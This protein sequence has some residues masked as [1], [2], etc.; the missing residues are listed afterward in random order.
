MNNIVITNNGYIPT[1]GDMGTPM[2]M[3]TP[4]VDSPYQ[5]AVAS[6]VLSSQDGPHIPRSK[7]RSHGH[8]RIN[9]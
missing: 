5:V 7:A 4:I 3:E 1:F 8:S 6:V 9:H 2:A